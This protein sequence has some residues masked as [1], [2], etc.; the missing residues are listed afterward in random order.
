MEAKGKKKFV[1]KSGKAPRGK[2]PHGKRKFKKDECRAVGAVYMD[3]SKAF[4][5]VSLAVLTEVLMSYGLDEQTRD[6]NKLEQWADRSLVKFKEKCKG[7]HLGGNNSVHQYMLGE[8]S[9]AEKALGL[10]MIT[11]LNVSQ[12]CALVAK[13]AN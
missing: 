2:G 10:L 4:G 13:V 8:G 6:L 11:K 12:Q 3:Y 9:F 7:L 1:G 5:S